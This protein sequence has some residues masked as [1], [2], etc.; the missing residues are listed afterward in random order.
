M[1]WSCHIRAACSFPGMGV[2]LRFWP[3]ER[4]LSFHVGPEP[5]SHEKW[6]LCGHLLQN[7]WLKSYRNFL[8]YTNS[9]AAAPF[10]ALDFFEIYIY[11]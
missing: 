2:Y 6:S 10:L 3:R 8:I 4:T 7:K 1:I 5:F 9:L 11:F